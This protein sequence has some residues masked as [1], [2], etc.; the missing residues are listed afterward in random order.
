MQPKDTVDPAKQDGMI[1]MIP[2][3]CGKVNIYKQVGTKRMKFN[4]V[5][6]FNFKKTKT[7][8]KRIL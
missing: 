1:Y 3:E 8:L 6:Y 7:L 2:C 5:S 4:A